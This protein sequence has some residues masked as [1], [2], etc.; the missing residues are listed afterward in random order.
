MHHL[1]VDWL[2]LARRAAVWRALS[3]KTRRYLLD[4]APGDR[5]HREELGP[6]HGRLVNQKFIDVA[7]TGRISF[8]PSQRPFARALRAM[9]RHA[10]LAEPAPWVLADYLRDQYT[11]AERQQFLRNGSGFWSATPE[12]LV[13]DVS[14]TAWLRPA[15]EAA[16]RGADTQRNAE[17]DTVRDAGVLVRTVLECGGIL[18][19]ENLPRAL[20]RDVPASR[21][22][23]AVQ[24]ALRHVWVLA[25]MSVDD[26]LPVLV[27]WPPSVA[28]LRRPPA[29]AP[30]PAI[31]AAEAGLPF[32]IDD[33]AAL[34]I[35]ASSE[36]LRLRGNDFALFAKAAQRVQAALVPLPKLMF[37]MADWNDDIR[38]SAAIAYMKSLRYVQAGG[39]AGRNLRLEVTAAGRAWLSQPAPERLR[40]LID[41]VRV[42]PRDQSPASGTGRPSHL[43]VLAGEEGGRADVLEFDDDLAGFDDIDFDDDDFDDLDPDHTPRAGTPRL[44][45]FGRDIRPSTLRDTLEAAVAEAY[46]RCNDG[47][48]PVNSFARYHAEQHNPLVTT[49]DGSGWIDGLRVSTLTVEEA[50]DLWVDLLVGVLINRLV[51]LGGAVL[52][53]VEGA[54]AGFRLTGAGR[55]ILGLHDRFDVDDVPG[56]GPVHGAPAQI[57][58]QPNFEIVFLESAAADEAELGRFAERAGRGLGTLFR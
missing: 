17:G 18:A 20:G 32:L 29:A 41:F 2:E 22:S 45:L 24:T 11:A 6:D 39:T 31:P 35:A 10:L 40:A 44:G 58:V 26:L 15:L 49:S 8:H 25:T 52:G 21:L 1:D 7:G 30:Q 33:A 12:A 48:V 19:V 27:L 55:V 51:P 5:L 46:R 37:T 23:A 38:V 13:R 47:F 54:G 9:S 14:S 50:E 4:I 57:I 53:H 3:R 42:C 16:E 56:L 28:R 36:P 34:L 43:R